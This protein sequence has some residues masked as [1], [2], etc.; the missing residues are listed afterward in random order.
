MV[1][2]FMIGFLLLTFFISIVS[3]VVVRPRHAPPPPRTEMRSVKPGP[4]FVWIP[5]HWK[6]SHGD[7]VWIGGHWTKRKPGKVWVP[8]HWVKRGGRYHWVP[9]HWRR[10]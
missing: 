8:G 9:G 7:W 2:R 3:C 6:W 10:R 1:K 4:N 5:G